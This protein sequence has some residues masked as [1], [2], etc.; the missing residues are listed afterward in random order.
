MIHLSF[1]IWLAV[2]A[3]LL[4]L[5]AATVQLVAVWFMGGALAAMLVS[6]CGLDVLWQ[7]VVFAFFSGLSLALLRPLLANRLK[8]RKVPTNAD[9]VI[10]Q[11]AVVL[12]TIDN[13]QSTGRVRVSGL[14]WAARSYDNTVISSG[15]KVGV[16]AIDGVKLIVIPIKED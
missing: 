5:E 1:W 4:I 15:T 12:E 11:T 14:G 13:I 9:M 16:C 2:L 6:L 7:V 8:A 10:G 3:A